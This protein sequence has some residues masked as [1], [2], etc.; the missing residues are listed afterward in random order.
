MNRLK[1]KKSNFTEY[2]YSS[3]K[4]GF[5]TVFYWLKY[6]QYF[7]FCHLKMWIILKRAMYL[8]IEK[9]IEILTRKNISEN[10]KLK[11]FLETD[12]NLSSLYDPLVQLFKGACEPVRSI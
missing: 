4:N 9:Y 3:C 10:I 11:S 1:Y 5:D 2:G 7:K 8:I 6:F 12:T